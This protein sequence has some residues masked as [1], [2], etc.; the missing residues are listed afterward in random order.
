M[1]LRARIGICLAG[2]LVAIGSSCP[3]HAQQFTQE[4]VVSD[5]S[6]L[7]SRQ[8]SALI[9]PFG[10]GRGTA[11]NW[12][13]SNKGNGLSTS[14][15][16]F[17]D[18][19]FQTVT[20]PPASSSATTSQP[21]GVVFNGS[22]GFAVT[23]GNPAQY[24]FATADGT[25]AA[26]SPNVDPANAFIMVNRSA[27]SSYTGVTIAEVNPGVF[28]LFAANFKAGT[29]DV[30]DSSFHPVS[31]SSLSAK[32]FSAAMPASTTA[33]R[34]L[35]IAPYNIQALG[36]DLV[37]TFA[38][39]GT[40]GQPVFG[41][42][43]GLVV[44]VDAKGNLRNILQ[45]GTFLNAPWG[46]AQAPADFGRSSHL[47]LIGNSGTGKIAAFDPF[48]GLFVS[49][50]LDQNGAVIS[51]DGLRALGFGA[52]G[53]AGAVGFPFSGAFNSLYFTAGLQ[54][55]THGLIGTLTP[56]PGDFVLGEQ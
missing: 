18:P 25:I 50:L 8:D 43:L 24:I 51:I 9:N 35:P 45:P 42:G 47:L 4:N 41:D 5:I 28:Y 15:D 36:K 46:I 37:I 7:A 19:N 22:N 12:M 31:W 54:G 2:V 48:S 32:S 17:G 38:V 39:R 23:P 34:T 55:G 52:T 16:G 49:F 29:I 21:T 53:A 30:F 13:V 56:V 40:N 10:F 33:A 6:G 44:I 14:Y 20:I 1:S 3:A 11:F 27:N 26:F